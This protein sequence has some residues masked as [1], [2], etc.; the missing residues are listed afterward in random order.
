MK[1]LRKG[2]SGDARNDETGGSSSVADDVFLL[3]VVPL[4]R[5]IL[6]KCHASTVG[7]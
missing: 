5:T 3:A 6:L 7:A 2:M 1:R 4:K